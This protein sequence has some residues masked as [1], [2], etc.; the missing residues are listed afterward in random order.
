MRENLDLSGEWIGSY[1]VVEET[2]KIEQTGSFVRAEKITQG[3][4]VPSGEMTFVADLVSGIG[5][6]RISQ[7]EFRNDRWVPGSLD[8][9]NN[10]CIR[11]RWFGVG[12]VEFRRDE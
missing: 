10:D 9:I 12:A 8:I 4:Y 11:F 1:P 6:G 5:S 7:K 3:E 2:I